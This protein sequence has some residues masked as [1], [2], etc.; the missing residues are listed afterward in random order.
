MALKEP[1]NSVSHMVGAGLAM[2]A[3][4]FLILAADG[5][6]AVV[7][8]AVYGACLLAVFTMSAVFHGVTHRKASAWL[9]R[10]DQAAIYL[11]IAGT[12]TPL[13]LLLVGG[14]WGWS[15][16]GVQWGLALTGVAVLLTVHRTP[17]WLHQAAYILL[18]WTALLALPQIDGLPIP[19][20]ALVVGG[21]LAYT[22]GATLYWRDRA[23]T[24][25]IGDHGIWHLLVLAGS[26]AHLVFVLVYV[27]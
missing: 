17:P 8:A 4:P 27:L 15:L 26:M 14:A 6:L 23:G 24:W 13:A 20:L 1:F 22:G 16:F 7:A 21:G 19:A 11:L 9:F 2:A 25:A 18:G 5:P 3:L 12:Y 10:L